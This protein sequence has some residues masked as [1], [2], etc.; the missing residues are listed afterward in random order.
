MIMNLYAESPKLI[1][2]FIWDYKQTR[3]A[4]VI[5]KK[6]S[7]GWRDGSGVKNSVVLREELN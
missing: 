5:F 1:L 4:Q 3:I 6:K 2:K 7:T